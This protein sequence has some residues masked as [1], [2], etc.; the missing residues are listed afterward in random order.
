VSLAYIGTLGRGKVAMLMSLFFSP[1]V[2]ALQMNKIGS[3]TGN[4]SKLQVPRVVRLLQ[5]EGVGQS[6]FI[7]VNVFSLEVSLWCN[8]FKDNQMAQND[9]PDKHEVDQ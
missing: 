1:C 4:Y 3:V 7:A 9:D 6:R 8:K 5:A 2:Q